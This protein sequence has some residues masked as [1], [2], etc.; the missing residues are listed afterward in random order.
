[1]ITG[2]IILIIMISVGTGGCP[3]AAPTVAGS[4][5]GSG[6]T[7]VCFARRTTDPYMLPTCNILF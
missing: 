2:C 3:A 5:P 6:Q 4:K 1:M 7:I